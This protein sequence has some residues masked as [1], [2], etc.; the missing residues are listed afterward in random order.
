MAE[1]TALEYFKEKARMTKGCKIV[2]EKCLLSS[3]NNGDRCSCYV[4]ERR[5]PEKAIAIVQEWAQEYPR[6]TFLTDF[7]E[8]YPNAPLE[9]N[10]IP[11]FCIGRL[12][13]LPCGCAEKCILPSGYI[14]S[15]CAPCW[16]QRTETEE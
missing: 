13:N 4:L 5:C 7:L 12:G 16:N 9:D 3:D 10:G 15:D 2:C 14:T 6:K 8:K 11:G 1:M